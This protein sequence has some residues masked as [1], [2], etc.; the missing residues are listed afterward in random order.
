MPNLDGPGLH[1]HL[2]QH[3]PDLVSRLIFITG[4]VLSADGDG[5]IAQ[6]DITVLEKPIDL[7]VL[8]ALVARMLSVECKL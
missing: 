6:D 7:T 1:R 4:D 3:R 5:M 8:R 2:R